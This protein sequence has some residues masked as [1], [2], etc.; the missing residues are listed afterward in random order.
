MKTRVKIREKQKEPAGVKISKPCSFFL[1][2]LLLAASLYSSI[3]LASPDMITF[4]SAVVWRSD[5]RGDYQFDKETFSSPGIYE[6]S[7]GHKTDGVVSGIT[8]S[9]KSS[10]QVSLEVSADDGINYTPVVCGQPLKAEEPGEEGFIKG[11][12]IRWKATLGSESV[13]SEVRISYSD[14]SGVAGTFGEPKL[15]GFK[16][17]KPLFITNSGSQDLFNYQLQIKVSELISED[18]DL[19]CQGNIEADFADIRFTSLDG[20]TLLSHYLEKITGSSPDRV[21]TFWVKLPQI[22]VSG[23]SIYLYYGNPS[24][25]DISSGQDVFDFFDGF[26]GDDLDLEKWE[27]KQGNLTVSGLQLRL[28]NAE[29]VSKNYL[30][31][32]GIIEYRART[33]AGNEVRLIARSE[34]DDSLAE[35]NQIAYS[36]SY[37]GIEHCLAVGDIVKVNQA[38]ALSPS[39]TY[40]YRLILDGTNLTFQRYSQGFLDLEAETIYDDQGGLTSGSIG[41]ESGTDCVS[42]FEWVRVRK[43]SPT[44]TGT[45][46]TI[47]VDKEAGQLAVAEQVDL[48]DFYGLILSQDGNLTLQDDYSQGLYTSSTL[49]LAEEV[50]I[51]VPY[52][53]SS[54]ALPLAEGAIS[55]DV[56]FDAGQN[57]A[58]GC[59]NNKFYYASKGDFAVG[60]DLKYRLSLTQDSV[61]QISIDHRPGK[62][63]LITPNGGETWPPQQQ[64]QII[65]SA[66]GYEPSHSMKIE[67]SLDDGGEYQTITKAVDNAG[68]YL[69]TIPDLASESVLIR[70]SDALDSEIFDISDEVFSISVVEDEEEEEEEEAGT[71]ESE[72][73]KITS[74]K[75][76]TE[77]TQ[78]PGTKLYD[79]V[80][81]MGD[82]TNPDP[83][84]DTQSC[85]KEGDIVM[86]RP[87]GHLW[88][89]TERSKFLIVHAYLTDNQVQ[90][91][92]RPKQEFTG[93]VDASGQ[94]VTKVLKR[95]A[96][97]LNLEKLGVPEDEYN[98]EKDQKLGDVRSELKGKVL[99]SEL[100]EEKE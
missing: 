2:L 57:F 39:S 35:A 34:K 14:S 42:Y 100:F 72:V 9:W 61:E 54:T 31:K 30:I 75:Q 49:T 17:R 40:D 21:A 81:K 77:T 3:A 25:E 44:L 51:F 86:I 38:S 95:R 70:I 23:L 87:T 92:V 94:P 19:Y 84:E 45:S 46:Y 50:R 32:D 83:E 27:V 98:P 56:S 71:E 5:D 80:I 85:Y 79:V 24:A 89:G 28:E 62:I 10:G 8:A 58:A 36:S 7:P 15:S 55:L 16:F 99:K 63:L 11:N 78:R 4:K 73:E 13:L 47:A 48:P 37:S 60:S 20:Q 67:Y 1:F 41:L 68:V 82:N 33:G 96:N 91:L 64:K 18:A 29:I 76:L 88:S 22:P 6:I 52:V 65:W 43:Y 59:L 93:E 69:W 12:R 74:L 66:L 90:E 26:S 97:K 53:A